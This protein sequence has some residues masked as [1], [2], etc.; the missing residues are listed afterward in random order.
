M[1]F[2][3]GSLARTNAMREP[4]GDQTA[5]SSPTHAHAIAQKRVARALDG[6]DLPAPWSRLAFDGVECLGDA[7]PIRSRQPLE[8]PR[9]LPRQLDAE[10][11]RLGHPLRRGSQ[12]APTGGLAL[13]QLRASASTEPHE[14]LGFGP[15]EVLGVDVEGQHDGHRSAAL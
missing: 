12:G 4:S 8:D 15:D 5:S 7:R 13:A 10:G 2:T 3:N 14:G 1:S 11:L 9:R 6:L